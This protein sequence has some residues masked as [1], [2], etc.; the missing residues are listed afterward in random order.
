MSATGVNSLKP[1]PCE[2]DLRTEVERL[3]TR[4]A[5]LERSNVELERVV[6]VAS[7]DLQE[8]LRVVSAYAQLL[9]RKYS[10]ALDDE[11]AAL[12]ENIVHG[13]ARMRS[14]VSDLLAYGELRERPREE[15][16]PVDLNVALDSAIQN[17]KLSIE[18]CNAEI[19]S[20]PLPVLRGNAR[21]FLRLFQNLLSNA[22]QYRSER[23]PRIHVSFQRGQ[24]QGE[25]AVADNGIGIDPEYHRRIFEPMRRLHG[26]N[27]PG[28][29]MGLAICTRLIE[30]YGGRIWVES[31]PGEGATFRF[32]LPDCGAQ[33]AG[34]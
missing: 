34:R 31:R 6:F 5:D 16:A 20:G 21:D 17:L 24:G 11:G 30:R 13:A 22:I 14:L 8:P 10:G 12:L 3:A 29:G 1:A 9:A 7:H 25:F 28:T 15:L 32:T 26:K 27:I 18:E 2:P 4:N 19:T 23:Q 33:P